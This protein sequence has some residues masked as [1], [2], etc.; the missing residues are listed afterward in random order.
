MR[1]PPL[2]FERPDIRLAYVRGAA[3]DAVIDRLETSLTA[4]ANA[5]TE[6]A[7]LGHYVTIVTGSEGVGKSRLLTEMMARH[8]GDVLTG[9]SFDRLDEGPGPFALDD[10]QDWPPLKLFSAINSAF[11]RGVPLVIAGE[12]RPA[13]WVQDPDA[14]GAP[15]LL[16]RLTALETLVL[17]AP[18]EAMI[19]QALTD[20]CRQAG[21][22]LPDSTLDWA[23][24][25]LRRNFTAVK[26]L[27][28]EAAWRGGNIRGSKALLESVM[29]DN[30]GLRL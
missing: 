12:G 20:A 5:T 25:C 23:A 17:D 22:A 30:P 15:D 2:P 21:L 19:R 14:P 3:N 13:T 28:R 1:Q 8:G 26:T 27:A 10:A 18:D 29:N 11:S 4:E 6:S 24:G 7:S 9:E 16:S